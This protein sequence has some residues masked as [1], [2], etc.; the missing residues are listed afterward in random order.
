MSTIVCPQCNK[1]DAIQ[2]VSAVVA[3]G[4]STGNFSGPSGGSLYMDGK[5]GTVSSYAHL[6]GQSTTNLANTIAAPIK[7]KEPVGPRGFGLWWLILWYPALY[8]ITLPGILLAFPGAGLI[9]WGSSNNTTVGKISMGIGIIIAIIGF[10]FG[11]MLGSRFVKYVNNWKVKRDIPRYETEISQWKID[12]EKW[13]SAM[14]TWNRLY[15]CHRNGIIFDSET[16]KT[17]EP[18]NINKYIYDQS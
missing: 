17:C 15:Y 1:D 18:A 13:N 3:G 12:T 7:P 4:T 5:S 10:V 2:K 9:A 14:Q 11:C 6:S 8:A 16:G